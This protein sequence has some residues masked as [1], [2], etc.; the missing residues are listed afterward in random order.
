[1][2][3]LNFNVSDDIFLSHEWLSLLCNNYELIEVQHK[4]SSLEIALNKRSKLGIPFGSC[5]PFTPYNSIVRHRHN[6]MTESVKFNTEIQLFSKLLSLKLKFK[7]IQLKF[8]SSTLN[9]PL[10]G[11]KRI[12]SKIAYTEI[13]SSNQ[14]IEKIWNSFS[15][16]LRNNILFAQNNSIIQE[17]KD[18]SIATSFLMKNIYYQKE[19]LTET[20]LSNILN[21]FCPIG[22]IKIFGAFNK[23]ELISCSAFIF[24]SNTLYYWLN[25]NKKDNNIRGS[26]LALIWKGIQTAIT[27]KCNFNFEG[28]SKMELVKVFKSFGSQTLIYPNCYVHNNWLIG[29]LSKFI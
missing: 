2:E 25:C 26:H 16:E 24:S 19:G 9:F 7:S 21:K 4:D 20:I 23:T 12:I 14:P 13:I 27:N 22:Q 28:S 6:E 5:A 18:P 17:I 10:V 15:S 11:D 1:M 29:F 8:S 3:K